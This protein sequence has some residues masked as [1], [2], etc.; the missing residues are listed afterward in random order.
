MNVFFSVQKGFM[1][2]PLILGSWLFGQEGTPE[3]AGE[4]NLDREYAVRVFIDC[5][6]C[7]INYIRQEIPY[8]NYVRDVK[9]AQVYVLETSE[10][11]GS[12][13]RKYTYIF[14]G[15]DEFEGMNDTLQYASRPD[16]SRDFIRTWRTQMLKMG[17]MRYVA[18]T[19]LYD[20]VKIGAT[21]NLVQQEVDDRWNNWVFELEAEPNFNLEESFKEFFL[22]SSASAVRITHKCKMEYDF[23]NH[24]SR[25]K[26]TYE[27]TLYTSLSKYYGLDV[28]I[29]KSLGEHWSAGLRTDL[30]SST[31]SNTRFGA[32]FFPSVEYNIFPYSK[33][34]QR[35]F[36]ILYGL[37][38]AYNLYNDTTIYGR[39]RENL[40]LHQL[41]LAYQVV[42]KW[43]SINI[44]LEGSNY[45]HDFSKNRV[46]LGGDITIRIVKGLS[47]RMRGRIARIDDQ[48][49]LRKGDLSE[50]DI[51]LQLTE[52][53]TN[54]S[55]RGEI[56]LT[57]TFGSIYN[58][59][60]NP[61]F[62]NGR[63]WF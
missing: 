17:L 60:V 38:G 33:S 11:T 59:I 32:D 1:V 41:Q 9:E 2:L 56:G 42:E 46:E 21:E 30:V 51:L 7:D 14:L 49:S 29:V 26:Y 50:A 35:Q 47:L 28:L 24:F 18:R 48:L 55:A 27:D 16:D 4:E 31:F 54:Y 61:R 12:G 37:G 45:F 6:R 19:P 10:H 8:V 44:S 39:I 62:G 20:E 22:R 52:M 40:W 57:Y 53:E 63:R 13:G 15:Q 58:N 5:D 25:T 36:R 43:G 3:E 34:S 23:D